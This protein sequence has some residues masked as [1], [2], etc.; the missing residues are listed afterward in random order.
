MLRN[1]FATTYR[2]LKRHKAFSAINILGLAIGMAACLLILQYVTF[3]LGFDSF[4]ENKDHIYRVVLGE[5]IPGRQVTPPALGPALKREI[6]EVKQSARLQ[7]ATGVFTYQTNTFAEEASYY[8]DASFLTMFSYPLLKGNPATALIQPNTAVVSQKTTRKYFGDTDPLGKAIRMSNPGEGTREILITGVLQDIPQYSHL[9][10]DMLLSYASLQGDQFENEWNWRSFTTYVL[11]DPKADPQAVAAKLPVSFGKILAES[12]A[13]QSF[14]LQPLSDIHVSDV[15]KDQAGADIQMIYF[16]LM[17]AF[18]ILVLAWINYI[19]LS[20]ARA[21]ERAKEVGVRKAIGASRYELFRQF[22]LEST[23]LNGL[24]MII[25]FTIVQLSLPYFRQ[26]TGLQLSLTLW[27]EWRFWAALVSLFLIGSLLSGLY[28]AMVLS[29]FKPIVVL[30]GKLQTTSGGV[31]LRKSLVVVQ[32]AAS[33]A[34]L[35]GTFTVYYQMQ[36]MR[37]KDLGMNIDQ[38][39]VVK[40]PKLIGDSSS[41]VKQWTLFKTRMQQMAAVKNVTASNAIPSRAY[42]SYYKNVTLEG[43][44]K[45][46]DSESDMFAEV[47]IDTD[48]FNTLSIPMAAGR[49]FSK[50]LATDNQATIVNEETLKKLHITNPQEAIGKFVQVGPRRLTI[51][52]VVKN[53]HHEHLKNSYFPTV[54]RLDP[55]S[56][57]YFTLKINMGNNPAAGLKE[58]IAGAEQ[59][60]NTIYPGNPFDYFFLDDAFNQQYEA[61]QKLGSTIALFAF[62]A[63]LVACLGLFG[64]ASFTTTQ[65]TKE[66]GIRKVLGASVSDIVRLLNVNFLSLILL[67][68]LIA[69]PLAYWGMSK[70]LEN[71]EFAIQINVW[72]FIV[73]ALLVLLIAL[74]TISFQTIKAARANPVKSLKY[75]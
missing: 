5:T 57:D 65:R 35:A 4:H 61:D 15:I 12:K 41:V 10:F 54:F 22:L 75:E 68:N 16:L 51:I 64:L 34:L 29:S 13:Y 6:P 1:Y 74:L 14:W 73:P 67:S 48:F 55:A 58:T 39:L 8:A 36:Y 62:L 32:F 43:M 42:N 71:Y 19:N 33:I 40:G 20:T 2:N 59:A 21:I 72:L 60:W 50:D 27:S 49:N 44:P 47:K 30:K 18:F 53:Y 25:A 3:Q 70:W 11:L 52:G 37:N 46:E 7:E 66:I 69:W 31:S 56:A 9:Q 38:T 26:L 45:K 28:P 24:G 17:L 63:I 23:L